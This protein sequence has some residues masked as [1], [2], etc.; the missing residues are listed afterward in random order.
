MREV[1]KVACKHPLIFINEYGVFYE[2]QVLNHFVSSGGSSSYFK[3]NVILEKFI[4][5]KFRNSEHRY[6][7]VRIFFYEKG[8]SY[9][10][11]RQTFN[12]S[13]LGTISENSI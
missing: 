9:N 10:Y 4:F 6:L 12:S 13:C 8:H 3:Q 2:G 7:C 1:T 5:H 11:S